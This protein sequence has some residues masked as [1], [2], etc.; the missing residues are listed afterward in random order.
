MLVFM[1]SNYSPFTPNK[2][3]AAVAKS[4]TPFLQPLHVR[5]YIFLRVTGGAVC[6]HQ[7]LVHDAYRL[8]TLLVD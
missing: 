7:T 5:R 8:C 2:A 6:R 3:H 4:G 1:E